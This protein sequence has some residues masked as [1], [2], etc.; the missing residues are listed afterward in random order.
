M[1]VRRPLPRSLL[2][3]ELARIREALDAARHRRGAAPRPAISCAR[4]AGPA[5]TRRPVGAL[6]APVSDAAAPASRPRGPAPAPRRPHAPPRRR[7]RAA[8]SRRP[9]TA[10]LHTGRP[11]LTSLLLAK[12]SLVG[13]LAT[14]LS[15]FLGLPAR[16]GGAA[17]HLRRPGGLH[18]P[19]RRLSLEALRSS[20]GTASRILHHLPLLGAAGLG[21]VVFLAAATWL[22]WRYPDWA[23]PAVVVLAP[24][25][26][27]LPLG[28]RTQQPARS[29]VPRAARGRHRRDRRPRPPARARGAGAPTRC[30]SPSPS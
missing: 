6:A 26:V 9:P 28:T 17:P 18:R 22:A 29:A 5:A 7:Q 21:L 11:A 13:L 4:R 16:R 12:L 19:A 3:Q 8:A 2:R 25:R 15:L 24:L 23:M 30:A 27:E 1:A 14:F 20:G 10:A